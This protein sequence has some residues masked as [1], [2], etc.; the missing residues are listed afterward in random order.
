MRGWQTLSAPNGYTRRK[1]GR[2]KSKCPNSVGCTRT[3]Q[4]SELTPQDAISTFAETPPTESV[5]FVLDRCMTG[6]QQATAD[7]KDQGFHDI[8]QA[9]F[10]SPARR[11]IV[12]KVSR[13]NDDC[14]SGYAVLQCTER[15]TPRNALMLQVKTP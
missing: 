9:H 1:K 5:K 15:K 3:K 10:H 6:D 8:S 12:I 11:T 2:C 7:V 4:V 13:E 14:K